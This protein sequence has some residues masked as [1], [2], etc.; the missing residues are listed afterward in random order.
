M[1]EVYFY[2]KEETPDEEEVPK[3]TFKKP[4]PNP[5]A[6]ERQRKEDEEMRIESRRQFEEIFTDYFQEASS[7]LDTL[8]SGKLSPRRHPFSDTEEPP[9]ELANRRISLRKFATPEPHSE[10]LTPNSKLFDR[11]PDRNTKSCMAW[12]VHRMLF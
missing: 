2:H 7:L 4:K 8:I 1:V 3:R 6:E 10:Q 11:S 5:E 12:S 9:S